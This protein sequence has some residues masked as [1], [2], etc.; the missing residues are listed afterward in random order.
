MVFAIVGL[1][2]KTSAFGILFG[3][4]ILSSAF[5][6]F[7]ALVT[8]RRFSNSPRSQIPVRSSRMLFTLGF[9]YMSVNTKVHWHP[10]ATAFRFEGFLEGATGTFIKV[11]RKANVHT[12]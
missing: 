10:L 2:G 5:V 4:R 9:F 3:I 6:L 8:G 1:T 12:P 11:G 7:F